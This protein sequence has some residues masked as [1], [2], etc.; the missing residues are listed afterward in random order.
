MSIKDTSGPAYP[1][2]VENHS[3]EPIAGLNND[4]IDAGKWLVYGGATLRDYF[5]IKALQGWL[6]SYG[7]EH[8]H[9]VGANSADFVA[10]EAYAMADAM[11]VERAK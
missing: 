11:L 2:K 9:P 4:L 1:I 8:Q 3:P 10:R 5:A 7:P 6:A